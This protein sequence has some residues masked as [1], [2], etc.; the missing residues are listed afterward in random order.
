[1]AVR[2][3][4]SS[5]ASERAQA[6]GSVFLPHQPHPQPRLAVCEPELSARTVVA[7]TSENIT[8]TAHAA[9]RIFL[10]FMVFPSRID[11]RERQ[12]PPTVGPRVLPPAWKHL[13]GDAQRAAVFVLAARSICAIA[14]E[15]GTGR[16]PTG[17]S[18]RSSGERPLPSTTS[19]LAPCAIRNATTSVQP[20]SAAENNA[21]CPSRSVIRL[22]R[23]IRAVRL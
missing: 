7:L 16:P 8:S 22:G 11:R 3:L 9:A 15:L 4:R 5:C 18:A 20:R 10:T 14:S 17:V 13:A 19:T 23:A 21:L 12:V 2:A 6:R 1:M